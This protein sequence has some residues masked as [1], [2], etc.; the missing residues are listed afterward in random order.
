MTDIFPFGDSP[1]PASTEPTTPEKPKN[2]RR[3]R[4]QR[5]AAEVPAKPPR[6]QRKARK[7]RTDKHAVGEPANPLSAAINMVLVLGAENAAVF[8][9]VA[10][11]LG[12]RSAAE[13]R[14]IVKYLSEYFA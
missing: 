13:R 10:T 2:G 9:D 6:K 7:P 3:K 8:A 12:S 1:A 4:R 14:K 5:S 11:R